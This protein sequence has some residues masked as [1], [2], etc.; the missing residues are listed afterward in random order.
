MYLPLLL[1]MPMPCGNFCFHVRD[2]NPLVYGGAVS[3]VEGKP[4]AG[5][6]VDV[7]DSSGKFI[8]WGK[9]LLGAGRAALMCTT[10]C[11]VALVCFA[12]RRV[13][14]LW[15]CSNQPGGCKA[16]FQHM[17]NCPSSTRPRSMELQY[18]QQQ[19]A[20]ARCLLG[21]VRMREQVMSYPS[22]HPGIRPLHIC[23]TA[24]STTPVPSA[25]QAKHLNTSK[26]ASRYLNRRLQP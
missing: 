26:R 18:A 8:A 4:V 23:R 7:V 1:F 25:R 12:A 13:Y 16:H 3:R 14:V 20:V 11:S 21:F 19:Q 10:R 9:S 24:S 17:S 15:L 6:L 22:V 5:D 2:G